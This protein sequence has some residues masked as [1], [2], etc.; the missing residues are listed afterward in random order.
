MCAPLWTVMH[1][2]D[3]PQRGLH[4]PHRG[5]CVPIINLRAMNNVIRSLALLVVL[6]LVNCCGENP[7]K[8]LSKLTLTVDSQVV[9]LIHFHSV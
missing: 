5:L 6:P 2:G 9:P 8:P 4:V 3:G 1:H 7:G